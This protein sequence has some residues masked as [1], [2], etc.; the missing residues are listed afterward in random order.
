VASAKSASPRS[1]AASAYV[2][3]LRGIN[4]GGKHSLP[5]A[6]LAAMFT[7]AG[8]TSVRTYIQSGNVV[9]SAPRGVDRLAR[10]LAEQIEA[11]FG[12]GVSVVMRTADE[13]RK[14]AS[15]N[16]FLRSGADAETLHVAFLADAPDKR[17]IAALDPKRSP[18]DAFQVIGREVYLN[19]PN[20]VAR[21]KLTNAYFDSKLAT[22]STL[23]N[24]RT[25]LKLVEL[26]RTA[27]DLSL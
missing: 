26:A 17:A 5:M 25:V 9:F 18:G 6:D 19:L 11:R 1:K 12:F 2:A 21:T 23:R 4:V 15:S 3:L 8:C 24:W 14:V 22:T 7:N 27:G 13:F 10:L 20:G 16:P